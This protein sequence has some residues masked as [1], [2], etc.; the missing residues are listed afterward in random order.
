MSQTHP[1][2]FS[3]DA[4]WVLLDVARQLAAP[5]DLNTLLT[6]VVD[7]GRTVLNAE[8]GSVFL[9]DPKKKELY[10]KV[11]TDSTEIRFGIETGIAGA[12]ARDRMTVNVPDCYADP[13]FNRE[14][15]HKT[16]YRTRALIAVPL[17]GL[18]R[19]LVGVLQLINPA[20]AAFDSNDEAIAH[21]I[22]SQ[23][24][25]A[26]HRT[27]LLEDRMEKIRLRRD[28]AVAREIQI[29]V[30]PPTLPDVHGYELAAHFQPAEETCG[31]IYDMVQIQAPSEEANGNQAVYLLLADASG[32]GIGPALSVTQVRSML[33]IGVLLSDDLD[34]LFSCIGYQLSQDLAASRFVTAFIGRLDPL[35]HR[36]E[37]HAGG[38]GP[39]L[40][41][42][43]ATGECLWRNASTHPLGILGMDNLERPSPI[44][45]D[46]GDSLIVLTDGF[47]EYHN[48]AGDLI[49]TEPFEAVCRKNA[50]VSAQALLK[51]L[52]EEVQQFAQGA[53][54]RD[55]L[56]GIIVR[57][58]RK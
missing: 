26:I 49:G 29:G 11:A 20:K 6:K 1:T 15:D 27:R 7:A 41:F 37:Y 48:A 25:V 55:D 36:I 23:A 39:L 16:G 9:Y 32:H 19:D 46:P 33:R 57:R 58:A 5:G 2:P 42:K 17:I 40:H 38:Q 24:A 34:R 53:P 35:T 12:C 28:L 45:M 10:S 18:D 30:L 44:M 51:A 14:F 52:V 13:R 54:Q 8:R 4:A 50:D 22:A 21:V 56:T 3:S 43:A 31:D 47:F